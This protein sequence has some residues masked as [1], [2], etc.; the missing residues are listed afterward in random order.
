MSAHKITVGD[1]PKSTKASFVTCFEFKVKGHAV[2]YK[3][4]SF[5]GAY[6]LRIDG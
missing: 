3:H 4:N 1:A 2:Q 5:S 6:Q